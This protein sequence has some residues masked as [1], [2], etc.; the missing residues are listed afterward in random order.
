MASY[1]QNTSSKLWSVRFRLMENGKYVNKRLSGYKTKKEANA[2]YV[3][4]LS[5]YEKNKALSTENTPNTQLTYKQLYSEF[6]TFY[7]PRVKKSTF[8]DFCSKT[9]LHI[10]PYFENR[11]V[12]EIKAIDILNWQ[13]TLEPYSYKYKV[14]LR[15]YL[16]T[17]LKYA[18]KYYDIPNQLPKVDNFRNTGF[19]P[20]MRF[21]TVG[22]Y[23]AF[24][25][26]AD[27]IDFKTFFEFLYATG[28]RKGEALALSWNDVDLN[29]K[30]VTFNKS[31]TRKAGAAWT[32]TTTKNASSVRTISLPTVLVED[33]KTYRAWQQDTCDKVQF[34]FGGAEP[35]PNTSIDRYFQKCIDLANVKRIR[36]HDLR[37]S[38]ASFL[39]SENV[40]IVAVA[41]RLG[42]SNIEQ[43]L[44]TY[45]HL[46]PKEDKLLIEKLDFA[47]KSQ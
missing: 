39:I 28:C 9:D 20:E 15:G 30:T 14:M 27:K 8:Y 32:V 23:Q 10:L 12:A 17:V 19:K 26:Q 6:K 40:S 44:N 47:L 21:W 36:I 29:A 4:F 13:N 3:S 2:G 16:G 38:H 7:E 31:I 22:E 41:K 33:L 11:R 24:I 1:E 25:A 35:F 34:V 46:M 45:A 37:H 5:E 18:D 43:T 42:H